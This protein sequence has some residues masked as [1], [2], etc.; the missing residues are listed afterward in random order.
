M[1]DSGM[2]EDWTRREGTPPY[3]DEAHPFLPAKHLTN[4]PLVGTCKY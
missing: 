4:H 3:A 2:N 1:P